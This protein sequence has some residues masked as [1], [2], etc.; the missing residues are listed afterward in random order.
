MYDC[1]SDNLPKDKDYFTYHVVEP[2]KYVEKLTIY[3]YHPEHLHKDNSFYQA[4]LC[5]K[6]FYKFMVKRM[7]KRGES[8]IFKDIAS[9]NTTFNSGSDCIVDMVNSGDYT[10]EEAIYIYTH[11]C[12]RC[13]NVL[14]HKYSNGKI[15]Y[16][17]Y[18][19]EWEKANTV[20][21]FCKNKED[22]L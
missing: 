22:K 3:T 15:G 1:T 18:S 16:E 4:M 21:D 13:I 10:L 14:E 5:F 19:K 8:K 6:W 2:L 20:C 17:E 7:K 9:F 12:E 11:S